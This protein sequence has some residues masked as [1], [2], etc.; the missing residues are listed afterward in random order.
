M[1]IKNNLQNSGN[2]VK[3]NQK[4]HMRKNKI[5]I[6]IDGTAG[7]GKST[8]AKLLSEKYNLR[9]LPT[10]IYYRKLAKIILEQN[11][12]LEDIVKIKNVIIQVID[13]SEIDLID[14][15]LYSD[16]ISY[17]ASEISKL[18]EV[19]E[20]FF[21]LQKKFINDNERVIL[22]GRDTGSIIAP[23]ANIKIFLTADPYIRAQRRAKEIDVNNTKILQTNIEK[24]DKEDSIRNISPLIIP[25][26]ALVIDSSN[27]T[28]E[29]VMNIIIPFV[30]L[31]LD[32]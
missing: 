8:I 30:R 13:I 25:E 20:Y 7:S 12:H 11:I 6:T 26:G 31:K 24:R 10:G 3:L 22:E 2:N 28:I 23:N 29:E 5:I 19:R 27:L 17:I 16:S 9:Y 32:L 18:I 15:S 1:F 4:N 21:L 14:K